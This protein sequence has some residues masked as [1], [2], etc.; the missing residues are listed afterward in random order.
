[1]SLSTEM[2]SVL[3][4]TNSPHRASFPEISIDTPGSGI[5]TYTTDYIDHI[6]GKVRNS[7]L[8]DV[9]ETTPPE[10]ARTLN[11]LNPAAIV[12]HAKSDVWHSAHEWPKLDNEKAG[13][14]WGKDTFS[15]PDTYSKSLTSS[16]IYSPSKHIAEHFVFIQQAYASEL[17]AA[18]N[19]LQ[20]AA[21]EAY[22]DDFQPPSDTALNSAERL[23]REMYAIS[24]RRY[25]IYPTPDQEIAI[26]APGGYGRS[27][28]LLCDSDGGA[29]C[30]VNMNGDHRR[31]RY[32]STEILPDGFLREALTELEQENS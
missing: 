30:L 29:L 9:C 25:E 7:S 26:D 5:N 15:F 20:N 14:I 12:H 28:I 11:V 6:Q 32:S 21:N 24:S 3:F 1:M 13:Y 31:A 17:D 27:V 16:V 18:L 19:D 23:L 10:Q 2:E 8:L 22:E 4:G